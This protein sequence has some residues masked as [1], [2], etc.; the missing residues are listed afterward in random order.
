MLLHVQTADINDQKI[1]TML[2]HLNK[3][4]GNYGC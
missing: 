3:Q 1:L 4:A 2:H